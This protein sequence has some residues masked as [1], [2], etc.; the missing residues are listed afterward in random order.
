MPVK[1]LAS[2]SNRAACDDLQPQAALFTEV[3]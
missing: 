2:D 3:T 1:R